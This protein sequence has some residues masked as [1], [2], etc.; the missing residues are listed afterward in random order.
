MTQS[1][2]TVQ[3]VTGPR[4]W[5]RR[6]L[7]FL[8]PVL[9]LMAAIFAVIVMGQMKPQPEEKEEVVKALPVLTA[10]AVS[11]TVTLSVDA[12]GEV[13]PRT[14]I[15]LVPQIAG[16]LTYMSPKFIEGGAFTKGDLLIRVEP[17]EYELRVVQ[18]KAN[19]AQAETT[20]MREK[21]E[22]EIA[23]RDWEELGGGQAPSALTLRE[24]QMAEAGA[25]LEAAKAQLAEAELQ[26]RRTYI[27][28]PFTGRVATRHV[29]Q[30]AFVTTGMTIGEIYSTDIMDVRLPLTNQD[31]ARAGLTL[32][33]QARR[34]EGVPVGLS[35]DVAGVQ[36]RWTAEIVRTDSRFDPETRVLY[37]YA[38][39]HDPFGKAALSGVPLAPGIYV[40]AKI[41]GEEVGGAVTIPRAGL[42]GKD[43]I[44]I[45]NE[46]ETLDIRSVTVRAS[47]RNK[48]I[49]IAG[50]EPGEQVVTSP[51]RG[52][53][54]GMQVDIVDTLDLV[55]TPEDE[56]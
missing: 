44:Y 50:L 29:N 27:Y 53:A 48:A 51:I 2:E 16:R 49:I 40:N 26:L 7:V 43:Q 37:A 30:G 9:V 17:A 32:G 55:A 14:Q 8:L 11:E 12:Q 6:F 33:Y 19:V 28:A 20:V 46:D 52:A 38:E 47:D 23:R 34:G 10:E 56:E 18:A 25:R 15:N 21:S 42:R 45:A 5:L 1:R 41:Q 36:A 22:S 35:A 39:V 24:P 4:L 54:N 31:L 13:Q 3:Q